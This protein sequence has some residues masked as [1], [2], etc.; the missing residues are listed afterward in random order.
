MNKPQASA[1]LPP[2]LGGLIPSKPEPPLSLLVLTALGLIALYR[3]FHLNKK[4]TI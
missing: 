3:L 4:K 2:G 1:L